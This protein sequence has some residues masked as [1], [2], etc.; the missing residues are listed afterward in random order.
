MSCCLF[1]HEMSEPVQGGQ[2][3]KHIRGILEASQVHVGIALVGS[4]C[5]TEPHS[6]LDAYLGIAGIISIY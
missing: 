6:G 3:T 4:D 5:K 2:V 1:E